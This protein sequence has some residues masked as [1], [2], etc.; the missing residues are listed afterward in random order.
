VTSPRPR[1]PTAC[2]RMPCCYICVLMLLH[3]CPHALSAIYQGIKS[4][5]VD[6]RANT[7]NFK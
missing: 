1:P 7:W 3:M 4:E 5:M 6:T 2:L